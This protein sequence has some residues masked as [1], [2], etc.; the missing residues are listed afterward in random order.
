MQS[1]SEATPSRKDSITKHE[2]IVAAI[3]NG[4]LKGIKESQISYFEQFET[5][6][7]SWRKA[8]EKKLLRKIDFRLL[9]LLVLC[10][11]LN[12]L[13]RSNLAQA[14][15][16]GLEDDLGMEGTDFNLATSIFFVGYLLMQLP[17]NLLITRLKPSIYLGSAVAVWGVVSTCNAAVHSF[18]GLLAVRIMLGIAEAPFFPGIL[19]LI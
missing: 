7:D 9:P 14:R 1:V 15:L 8:Y 3:D 6:D 12:F 11:L 19:I 17:S 4:S 18:S 2:E 13:D 16:G 10:Y 5:Q